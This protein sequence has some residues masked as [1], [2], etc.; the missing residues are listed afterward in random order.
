MKISI[1]IEVGVEDIVLATVLID[2]ATAIMTF[3]A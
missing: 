2:L 1:S 3:L